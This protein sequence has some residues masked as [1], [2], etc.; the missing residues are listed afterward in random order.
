MAYWEGAR[1]G[2][3]ERG[4]PIAPLAPRRDADRK[5]ARWRHQRWFG[6]CRGV[7]VDTMNGPYWPVSVER[8]GDPSLRPSVT[9]CLHTPP[10]VSVKRQAHKLLTFST[11]E[12]N[13]PLPATTA[14]RSGWS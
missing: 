11:S 10:L 1:S 4:L 9:C 3:N 12:A 13:R 14:A 7:H 2:A 5:L 8:G 6:G